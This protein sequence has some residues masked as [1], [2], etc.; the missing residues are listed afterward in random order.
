MPVNGG[1]PASL[2][3]GL[4][5]ACLAIAAC[6]PAPEPGAAADD[7]P[8]VDEDGAA[9]DTIEQFAS[10]R[11]LTIHTDDLPAIRER[12][13]IRALVSF[14]RT[15]FYLRGTEFSGIEYE[16]LREYEKHL[17]QGR[18]PRERRIQLYYLPLPFDRLLPALSQG[19]G[20]IAAGGLTAT[21]SR[22]AIAAF[23]E[24]YITNVRELIVGHEGSR[25]IDSLDQLSGREVTVTRASSH[26][27]HLER[28]NEGFR[29]RGMAPVRIRKANRYLHVQDLLEM[30][31]AK[32]LE[33]TVA[34]EH[35]ARAW[36]AALPGLRLFTAAPLHTGGQIG[37][38]V[39]PDNPELLADVNR[40]MRA[41][42]KGTLL[43][44]LLYRRYFGDARR[45]GNPV[46]PAMQERVRELSDLFREFGARYDLDWRRLM[47]QAYQE[48]RLDNTRVSRAGAI[49]I[50]QVRPATAADPNVNIRNIQELRNNVHAGVK[51][52][53]FLRDRY[54]S[55]PEISRLDRLRFAQAAY[56]AG[57]RRVARMR[58]RAAEMGLDPN[59]WFDNVELAA[60]RLVGQETVRYVA[61]IEKYYLAIRL[62]LD[63]Q[64]QRRKHRERL[65]VAAPAA[66]AGPRQAVY[67]AGTPAG[68]PLAP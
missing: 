3:A 33:Y 22:R 8:A 57:P 4:L 65:L 40:F 58:K 9:D 35:L 62:Y 15:D 30:V 67:S 36:S 11:D 2:G 16:L 45:L 49:G 59:R 44:N 51:Y 38:A 48:S 41:H 68:R 64:Q 46:S 7:A 18:S 53:A 29:A 66:A 27:E 24:P 6:A 26:L 39:R 25:A 54:F 63:A 21:E 17:N 28:L 43:G 1:K 52:L 14:D 56:N 13:Y 61:N 31:D 47:A 34:D 60:L 19:L 10:Q 5:L 55:T 42:R 20:D 32:I 23:S 50:M 37:W 12:G